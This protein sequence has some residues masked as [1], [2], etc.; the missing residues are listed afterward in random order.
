[1]NLV[2]LFAV[3]ES[4]ELVECLK[5]LAEFEPVVPAERVENLKLVAELQPGLALLLAGFRAPF[6]KLPRS[7]FHFQYFQELP[8]YRG[9]LLQFRVGCV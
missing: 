8:K 6:Q 7:D 9:Q 3:A 4:V 2:E 5:T 1:M